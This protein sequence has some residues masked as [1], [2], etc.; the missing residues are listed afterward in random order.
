M[1][2]TEVYPWEFHANDEGEIYI[3][4]APIYAVLHIKMNVKLRLHTAIQCIM[5]LYMRGDF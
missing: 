3:K 1:K 5:C 2:I 4:C